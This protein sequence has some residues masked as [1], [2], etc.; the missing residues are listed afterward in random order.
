MKP[1]FHGKQRFF[2]FCVFRVGYTAIDGANGGTPWLFMK[3]HALR[4]A[5]NA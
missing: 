3:A 5:A 2:V 4:S 1:G